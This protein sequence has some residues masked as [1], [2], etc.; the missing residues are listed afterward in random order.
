MNF[1]THTS[2]NVA[3][4]SRF[5]VYM[6][7]GSVALCTAYTYY[8]TI[9]IFLCTN[10]AIEPKFMFDLLRS[11]TERVHKDQFLYM[12]TLN[13]VYIMGCN[14]LFQNMA[15]L[16][17]TGL[18]LRL[19]SEGYW[20]SSLVFCPKASWFVRMVLSNTFNP[21]NNTNKP[22]NELFC[23]KFGFPPDHPDNTSPFGWYGRGN[24]ASV[25]R[26]C[27]ARPVFRRPALPQPAPPGPGLA[28]GCPSWNPAKQIP[29]NEFLS[30][31]ELFCPKKQ[32]FCPKKS[33]LFEKKNKMR[34][35]VQNVL[36]SLKNVLF[37]PRLCC[38]VWKMCCLVQ[39]KNTVWKTWNMKHLCPNSMEY[40]APFS[41]PLQSLRSCHLWASMPV[42]VSVGLQTIP[43]IP[44]ATTSA[45]AQR[46]RKGVGYTSTRAPIPL[47]T[48]DGLARHVELAP[49]SH[50]QPPSE[51]CP[52]SISRTCTGSCRKCTS[53]WTVD[54]DAD[55]RVRVTRGFALSTK[56]QGCTILFS[57]TKRVS[58]GRPFRL[59][60]PNTMRKEQTTDL[61]CPKTMWNGVLK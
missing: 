9:M 47:I 30:G 37:S 45:A 49:Q 1:M 17:E 38:L 41:V 10:C 33:S 21:R 22:Q 56:G 32:L 2:D 7:F 43:G 5:N 6:M 19:L 12:K 34:C 40:G 39:Q 54:S 11:K 36:F 24:V 61:F 55:A 23:P 4:N 44:S 16:S 51:M 48:V 26:V 8:V 58:V 31:K 13:Y 50:A 3:H 29:K 53:Q 52:H 60:S 18:K 15:V 28:S 20:F 42:S 46:R 27:P 57:L 25:P 59:R 35:L 14:F